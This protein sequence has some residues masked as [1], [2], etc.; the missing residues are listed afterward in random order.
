[1]GSDPSW[2]LRT[3]DWGDG[4]AGVENK[5][6]ER[7]RWERGNLEEENIGKMEEQ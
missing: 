1:M 2:G 4:R 6:R 3:R 5:W 7:E